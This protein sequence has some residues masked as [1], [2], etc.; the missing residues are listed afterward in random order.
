MDG[1]VE[2]AVRGF[3]EAFE[4]LD[5][6]ALCAGWEQSDRAAVLH[7]GGRWLTGWEAVRESWEAILGGASY[8]EVE[9]DE[10]V[11]SVED[12]IAWATCVERVVAPG[13]EGTGMSEL[14]AMNV[15]AL[16]PTGWRMVVHQ[17]SPILRAG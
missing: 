3:Y 7:P 16:G 6:E 15:L 8:I 17:A 2:Q 4:R 1:Q 14:S 11:I 12:P 5:I 9:I 10:L 13:P